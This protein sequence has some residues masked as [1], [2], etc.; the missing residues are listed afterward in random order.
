[1]LS[2]VLFVVVLIV[3]DQLTKVLATAYLAPVGVMPFLPGIMEL[4][5]VLNDGMAF[6]M[7]A[8]ARWL[9][10]VVTAAA[11]AV[12]SW[13]AFT[14][15]KTQP[16]LEHIS[17]L[18]VIGGGIGNLIDR[19]LHGYVVDFF[20]TTFID[21]AVFNVADCFVVVGM[22]LLMIAI[23]RQEFGHKAAEAT[24]QA[25]ANDKSEDGDGDNHVG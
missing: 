22:T 17:L 9:L 19:V 14:K 24:S 21:F 11:L 15:K 18:L 3:L 10:I 4:R 1:M 20:A 13:W 25:T 8:G 6:S 5:Y 23:L 2:S 12:L 7:L 16:K